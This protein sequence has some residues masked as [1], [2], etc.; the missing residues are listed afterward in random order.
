MGS[1]LDPVASLVSA[2]GFLS[3][4]ALAEL[5]RLIAER[6]AGEVARQFAA[7]ES[8]RAAPYATVKEAADYLRC[9]RQRVDDLLSQGKLTRYKDGAR[10]LIR[11]DEL[12][13]HPRAAR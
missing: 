12:E 4:E 9:K 10:T 8:G 7:R 3:D 13:A 2:L 1:S 5:E 6:V 11:W